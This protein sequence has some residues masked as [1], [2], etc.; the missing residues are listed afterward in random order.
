M[1]D[2]PGELKRALDRAINRQLEAYSTQR[3]ESLGSQAAAGNPLGAA[4]GV[5]AADGAGAGYD[6]TETVM[7]FTWNLSVWNG[8][9]LWTGS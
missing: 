3:G 4:A 8:D 9:D 2:L 5:I 7:A 1:P 6:G